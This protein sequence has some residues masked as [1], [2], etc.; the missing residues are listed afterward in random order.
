MSKLTAMLKWAMRIVAVGGALLAMAVGMAAWMHR[1]ERREWLVETPAVCFGVLIDP[2]ESFV[3]GS[4]RREY[5]PGLRLNLGQYAAVSADCDDSETFQYAVM[6]A[7]Y[8]LD[9]HRFGIAWPRP[10]VPVRLRMLSQIDPTPVTVVA[11]PTWAVI[12]VL[13]LPMGLWGGIGW[14]QRRR[15]K[16]G[17]CANCGYD[18]RATPEKCPECGRAVKRNA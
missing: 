5:D 2:G 15:V 13:L 8:H 17:H 7:D 3:G 4:L 11:S 9:W 14:R 12:A 1:T 10:P 6:T 16:A 18:L